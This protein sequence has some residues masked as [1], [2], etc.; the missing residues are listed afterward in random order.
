MKTSLKI[1]ILFLCIFIQTNSVSA[2][3]KSGTEEHEKSGK[4]VFI[5]NRFVYVD[6]KC[7]LFEF[8]EPGEPVAPPTSSTSE[9]S[10]PDPKA[11]IKAAK[12][13]AEKYPSKFIKIDTYL[14]TGDESG[15]PM[16]TARRP[17]HI[18]QYFFFDDGD[19]KKI[20][21]RRQ[22]CV[23][24]YG[25]EGQYAFFYEFFGEWDADDSYVKATFEFI[26][27]HQCRF[28]QQR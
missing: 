25:E 27:D 18:M 16:I 26:D 13:A 22:V 2:A 17:T 9:D 19:K 14:N 15:S 23:P 1:L 6:P 8:A 7:D 3:K 11:L 21:I 12:W 28:R 4:I 5:N 20:R 24:V 10:A